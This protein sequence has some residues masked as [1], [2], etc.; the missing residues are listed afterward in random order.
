MTTLL[1]AGAAG[2]MGRMLVEE[3]AGVPELTAVI[4]LLRGDDARTVLSEH[5]PDLLLDFSLI[6]GSRELAVLAARAGVPVVVGVSGYRAEDVRMLGEACL[7]GS[8]AGLLAPNFSLG[9]VLQLR[10]AAELA[11]RIPCTGIH[12]VHHP[13]KRDAPSGTALAAAAAIERTSGSRPAIRSER[14]EGRL[15]EQTIRFGHPGEVC[16]LVHRVTDRRAYLPGVLLAL[17][18]VRSL[19][20][21]LHIGLEPLLR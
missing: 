16:E 8:V 20:V 1:L 15:A 3:L 13:G 19:P 6:E 7:D 21:G 18:G 11:A 14:L 5:H 9:A 10:H 17:R 2:R 4:P 12:E